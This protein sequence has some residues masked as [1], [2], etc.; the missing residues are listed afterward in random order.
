MPKPRSLTK[1]QV[2]RARKLFGN[3]KSIS[4]IAGKLAVSYGVIYQLVNGITYRDI[5]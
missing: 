5:D 3:G 1:A 4:D 2:R